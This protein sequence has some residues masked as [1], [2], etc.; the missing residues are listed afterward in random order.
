LKNSIHGNSHLLGNYRRLPVNF[1]SG[2]GCTL[3]DSTGRKYLDMVAGIAVNILGYSNPRLVSAICNQA[4]NLIHV[5]NLYEIDLQ[6]K[7]ASRLIEYLGSEAFAFYCNSGA[8]ANEAA[9]KFAVKHTGRNT[10]LTAENSFH[11][12]TA[13]TLSVTGQS[14]Y[15]KGF[16]PLI[17]RNVR[18]SE[19]GNAD[20]FIEKLDGDVAALIIEPVQGEGGVIVPPAGFLKELRNACRKNGTVLIVDEVQTGMGRT[21]RFFAHQHEGIEADIITLAKGLAGGV[22]A[23]AVLLRKEIASS[24]QPGDHGSTFGGNP[25]AMAASLAVLEEIKACR[26]MD[27]AVERGRQLMEGL[28][29]AFGGTAREIRGLGLM[30][31]IELSAEEA[32]RFRRF[33]FERGFIVNV[34]HETTVRLLPPLIINEEEVASFIKMARAFARDV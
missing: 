20:D 19:F 15:W 3:V 31:G 16:E 30:I 32:E 26:L 17:Y 7:V 27:N 21:G 25:L 12:R 22:P 24:I 18:F 10:I 1:I 33:A 11:G 13:L 4:G 9:I 14:K 29:D 5:S 23:G 34:T 8:E 6:E 28:K 2:K